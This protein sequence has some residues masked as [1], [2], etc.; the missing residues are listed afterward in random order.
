MGNRQV[1]DLEIG[2]P[3]EARRLPDDRGCT[4]MDGT[5]DMRAA[6]MHV[7]RISQEN[8]ARADAAA[9]GADVACCR[10]QLAQIG[11]HLLDV[12]RDRHIDSGTTGAS[13]GGA[14][15]RSNG[16]SG[17]S[18]MKR[19]APDITFENTGAAIRPP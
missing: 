12:V 5:G 16:A 4:R 2:L 13:P 15:V 7:A 19:S 3:V 1:L 17:G 14:L 10:R 11:D 9:V 18:A 8:V 6:V